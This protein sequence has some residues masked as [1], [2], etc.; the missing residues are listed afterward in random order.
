MNHPLLESKKFLASALA[1]ILSVV[2]VL[3]GVPVADAMLLVSPLI[4]GVAAQGVADIG[5]ER[6]LA[7]LTVD[8]TNRESRIKEE[9]KSSG[10]VSL[11]LLLP[12]LCLAL[13]A[14]GC[15]A[16]AR[17]IPLAMLPAARLTWPSIERDYVAGIEDAEAEN[18][19]SS[20]ESVELTD[21][22]GRLTVALQSSDIVGLAGI[23]WSVQ[24]Q[25]WASRGIDVRLNQGAIGE[26]GARER[27]GQLAEFTVSIE[28]L[29]GTQK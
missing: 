24:M 19:I 21:L 6:V 27:R 18:V 29:Q 22:Q 16:V 15:N 25:P 8:T 11:A 23:P 17:V 13:L 1:T 26:I 9:R 4:V 5:K 2:A 3:C 14:S 7:E 28:E 10:R 12:L 20:V